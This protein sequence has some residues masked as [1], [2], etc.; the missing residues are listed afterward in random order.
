MSDRND[1]VQKLRT[2]LLEGLKSPPAGVA[3]AE[4][5][6]RLRERS[7]GDKR[8]RSLQTWGEERSSMRSPASEHSPS[9]ATSTCTQTTS[10]MPRAPTRGP[11]HH[12]TPQLSAPLA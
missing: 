3:D 6:N 7:R 9:H 5:F 11:E 8:Q 12:T 4:Y 10:L 1:D 2:L